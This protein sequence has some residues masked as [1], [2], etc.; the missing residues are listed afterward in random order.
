MEGYS[1]LVQLFSK[2][3]QVKTLELPVRAMNWDKPSIHIPVCWLYLEHLI[4]KN[5]N[6]PIFG[7]PMSE[8]SG[9]NSCT[10]RKQKLVCKN[11][12][13]FLS[14]TNHL[15][16]FECSCLH[17]YLQVFPNLNYP[18]IYF[19]SIESSRFI[20]YSISFAIQ[21]TPKLSLISN[22][23][24][25]VLYSLDLIAPNLLVAIASEKQLWNKIERDHKCPPTEFKKRKIDN[26]CHNEDILFWFL[27]YHHSPGFPVELCC[28]VRCMHLLGKIV[29]DTLSFMDCMS[30]YHSH[31]C[32]IVIYIYAICSSF[33]D[34]IHCLQSCYAWLWPLAWWNQ[35]W[36][37][38]FFLITPSSPSSL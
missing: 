25:W 28:V 37:L 20:N 35:L 29:V 12:K 5:I 15:L 27:F 33:W 36:S 16:F 22:S 2:S 23:N 14:E 26:G 13:P 9:E 4:V 30:H 11:A 38:I 10:N 6:L 3:W 21:N 8:S 34:S 7:T 1:L 19:E 17:N 32:Y 31:L 24:I 18:L